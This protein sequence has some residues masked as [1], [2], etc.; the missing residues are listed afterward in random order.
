MPTLKN[1]RHEKFAQEIAKAK[2]ATAAM[3][4]AGYSDPRE[5]YEMAG[6]K[7]SRSNASVLR[8]NAERFRSFKRNIAAI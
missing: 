1:P 4:A 7:P 8:A 5:A 3:A 2:T 6:Y